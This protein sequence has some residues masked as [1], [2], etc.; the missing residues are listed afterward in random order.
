MNQLQRGISDIEVLYSGCER[1]FHGVPFP[2]CVGLGTDKEYGV[3]VLVEWHHFVDCV[4]DDHVD[5]GS[6]RQ[7]THHGGLHG[8]DVVNE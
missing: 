8:R 5:C 3:A 6:P 7:T 4:L 1:M 2:G